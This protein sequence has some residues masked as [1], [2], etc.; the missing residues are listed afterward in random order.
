MQNRVIALSTTTS[1]AKSFKETGLNSLFQ[2]GADIEDVVVAAA[3]LRMAVCNHY[4]LVA[5]KEVS[6]KIKPRMVISGCIVKG[7]AKR[8]DGV[9]VA[10]VGSKIDF[11]GNFLFC[12]A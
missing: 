7:V 11:H 10:F 5:D 2:F 9:N 1:E 6:F 4:T 3:H 12:G 8:F